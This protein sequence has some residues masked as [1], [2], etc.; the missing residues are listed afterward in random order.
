MRSLRW[1]LRIK[2][3][4][5]II[6]ATLGLVLAAPLMAVIALIVRL[7]SPGPVLFCQ[8][9]A[10]L[11]GKEFTLRKFRTMQDG[12]KHIRNKDGSAQVLRGD[13]R[14]TRSGRILREF[15]LDE[16]PQLWNVLWGEMS[17]VGPRP[18]MLSYIA[19]LSEQARR[20]LDMQPGLVCL[21]EVSGRN[22]LS[23]AQGVELDIYYV[24][25]WSHWLDMSILLRAIP[26]VLFR[27]GVYSNDGKVSN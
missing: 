18:Y 17:L 6:G 22:A 15:G 12:A 20:R 25:Q 2:R 10:G 16:L 3:I 11:K 23:L 26:V 27:K 9:R 14:L 1:T 5:D 8:K 4:I 13:A 21:A 7:D 24:D 19:E